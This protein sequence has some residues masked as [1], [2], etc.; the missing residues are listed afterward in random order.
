MHQRKQRSTYSYFAHTL[1]SLHEPL[2]GVLAVG[3]DGAKA[4]ISSLQEHLRFAVF[5]RC[6]IHFEENI[7]SYIL[8]IGIPSKVCKEYLYDIFGEMRG[9]TF[10]RG[11]VDS[12]SEAVFY[13]KLS[14]LKDI[15]EKREEPYVPKG[16]EPRIHD[17]FTKNKVK[18]YK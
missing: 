10:Y 17:W 16:K 12:T 11:I 9:S 6:F 8:S 7:K 3:T 4:L 18:Y 13:H 15:W 14:E 5:L 2:N 1:V